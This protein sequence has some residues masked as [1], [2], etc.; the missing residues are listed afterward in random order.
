ML[1]LRFRQDK[2]KENVDSDE[3]VSIASALRTKRQ[4]SLTLEQIEDCKVGPKDD[5][6]IGVPVENKLTE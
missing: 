2:I 4:S 1:L 3:N 6:A 5:K